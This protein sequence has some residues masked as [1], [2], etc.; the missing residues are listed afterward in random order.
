M[1]FPPSSWSRE[2]RDKSL[3]PSFEGRLQLQP[4]TRSASHAATVDYT[5]LYM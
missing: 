4:N 3:H 2:S 5:T 1:G